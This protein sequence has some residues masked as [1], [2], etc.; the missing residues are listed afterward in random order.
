MGRRGLVR[1]MVGHICYV[2]ATGKT[3][4]F[5][6]RREGKTLLLKTLCTSDIGLK[7]TELELT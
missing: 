3:G 1:E 6:M 5:G 2:G 4:V 7:G